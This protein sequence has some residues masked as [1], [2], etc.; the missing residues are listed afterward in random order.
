MGVLEFCKKVIRIR[1][2][3]GWGKWL[4]L[5]FFVKGKEEEVLI[6]KNG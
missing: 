5:D 1:L 4:D 3:Y 6:F 2:W